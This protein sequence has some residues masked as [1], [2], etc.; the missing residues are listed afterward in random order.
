MKN[1]VQNVMVLGGDKNKKTNTQ[2]L[3]TSENTPTNILTKNQ[4]QIEQ[5]KTT[6]KKLSTLITGYK[7]KE[8]LYI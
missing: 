7:N 1:F 6:L 8:V 2:H 3:H 4:L 5:Y